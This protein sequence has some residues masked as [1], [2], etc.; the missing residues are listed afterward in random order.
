MK[1]I[2]IINPAA[3]KTDRRRSI[4]QMGEALERNHAAEVEYILTKSHGHAE[5]A[6]RN[7]AQTGEEVR[8]YA[9][10]GD[11][12][13]NEV[14]NGIVGFENAAMTCIPIGTG[15]DFLK[16]FGLDISK[17]NDAENLWDGEV[18]KL[19]LIACNDRVC[20]TI[21]C[22]G[23]DARIAESVHNVGQSPL[24]TGKGSYLVSV[25]YHFLLRGIAQH[26]TVTLDDETIEDDFALVSVC[27]G[28]HYGG[29]V[30]PMPYADMTDGILQTIVVKNVSRAKFARLFPLYSA[31]KIDQIKEP[32]LKVYTPKNVTIRSEEEITT[33]LDGECFRSH[34]VKLS[35]SPYKLNFFGYP[36]CDPNATMQ[37][38]DE[39]CP[40]F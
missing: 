33:C 23:V 11:G 28:R 26:Y 25:A 18:Q 4:Y 40:T 1:H 38:K 2:F 3:G 17:F 39:C 6:V 8:F 29:S 21:A 5:Q 34:E 9:C 15:N 12:T 16:N 7:I 37:K 19:D 10:G 35:L 27:N 30:M 20:L 13:V 36:G 32:L 24:L 22:N 31:G 14:A